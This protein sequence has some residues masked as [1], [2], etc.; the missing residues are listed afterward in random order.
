MIRGNNYKPL[1]IGLTIGDS[2][3]HGLGLISTTD[4][5]ESTRLGTTHVF[6]KETNKWI[7]TPLGGFI[8]HSDEPNCFI[9]ND[10]DGKRVLFTVKP[11][12]KNEELCVFYSLK[13]WT[14]I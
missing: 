9:L 11:I 7:R 5:Q 2:D 13:E 8:N 4:I 12:R 1:P 14:N 6:H 10:K 3:I